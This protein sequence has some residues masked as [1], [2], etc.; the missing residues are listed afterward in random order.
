MGILDLLDDLDV[1]E[2]DVEVL[3]DAL[4]GAADLDVVLELDCDLVV[5]QG[6]EETVAL[7]SA[8]GIFEDRKSQR[9]TQYDAVDSIVMMVRC[10]W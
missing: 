3:V 7:V 5:D 1:L 2:L 10:S 4:K 8:C 9:R 6:L